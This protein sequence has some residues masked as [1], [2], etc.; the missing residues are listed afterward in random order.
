MINRVLSTH[1]DLKVFEKNYFGDGK[2]TKK[3]INILEAYFGR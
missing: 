1:T 3:I 2:A